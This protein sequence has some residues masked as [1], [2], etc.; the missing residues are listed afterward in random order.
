MTYR[1]RAVPDPT[2][3]FC[4]NDPAANVHDLESPW[5]RMCGQFLALPTGWDDTAYVPTPAE[6]AATWSARVQGEV[7][8]RVY[9]A[10]DAAARTETLTQAAYTLGQLWA[11]GYVNPRNAAISL[12]DVAHDV[13]FDTEQAQGI[14]E[15]HMTRGSHDPRHPH[16]PTDGPT[17]PVGVPNDPGGTDAPAGDH[18]ASGDPVVRTG[19]EPVD[20]T[21]AIAGDGPDDATTILERNDGVALLYPGKFHAINGESESGKTWLALA[22]VHEQIS[23]GHRVVYL[24]FEDS[25][26][27]IVRRLQLFGISDDHLTALL[28]YIRPDDKYT[29]AAALVLR[30]VVIGAHAAPTTLVVIDGVTEAMSLNGWEINNNDDVATFYRPLPREIAKA[31]PAVILIDHVT[32]DREGR[33]RYAIGGQHKLAGIDGAVYTV[34]K[35]KPFA[36]GQ[37]GT[38]R[39]RVMKDRAGAVRQHL[40]GDHVADFRL[41]ST[42]DGVTATLIAPRPS[43][44]ITAETFLARPE[45]VMQRISELLES[46]PDGVT[47]TA[48]DDTIGGNKAT[49]RQALNLL[50]TEGHIARRS[51]GR[52]RLISSAQ[53]Y[54]T[55]GAA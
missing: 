2:W 36:P 4:S 24:D 28:A 34:E 51:S 31:G 22:A 17:R 38:A 37:V 40:E 25:A 29:P 43:D 14:I 23:A 19:W 12:R 30:D 18:G 47:A 6:I 41:T 48:L 21:A 3:A 7:T 10:T 49:R 27:S 46:R 45:S 42:D 8:R 15:T 32:K 26:R 54:R 11:G 44:S 16:T 33:G 52:T 50:E 35:V 20:L 13:G 53:P 1:L 5:H 9:A 55:T 39:V